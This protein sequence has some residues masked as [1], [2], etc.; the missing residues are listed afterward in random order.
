MNNEE[1]QTESWSSV[2]RGKTHILYSQIAQMQNELSKAGMEDSSIE[3]LCKPYYTLLDS[4]F[5]EDYPLAKA[6]EDSD[7]AVRIEGK[8]VRKEAPRIAIITY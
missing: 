7:L 6:I 5:N 1:R 3:T 2:I 8:G 4:V